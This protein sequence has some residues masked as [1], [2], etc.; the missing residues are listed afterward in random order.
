[1]TP[2]RAR[3]GATHTHTH[4]LFSAFFLF[5]GQHQCLLMVNQNRPAPSIS[6]LTTT[7]SSVRIPSDIDKDNEVWEKIQHQKEI[8]NE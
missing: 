3:Q 7:L 5:L 4:N 2:K 1:M 8:P 6:Q